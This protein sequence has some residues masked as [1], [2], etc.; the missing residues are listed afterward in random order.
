ME[1]QI[2]H[3]NCPFCGARPGP[4]SLDSFLDRWRGSPESDFDALLETYRAIL[5]EIAASEVRWKTKKFERALDRLRSWFGGPRSACAHQVDVCDGNRRIALSDCPLCLTSKGPRPPDRYFTLW[6]DACSVQVANFFY[7]S[8]IV[9]FAILRQL[10]QWA[11]PQRLGRW[12]DL[13]ALNQRTLGAVGL[14]ECPLC[15]RHTTC[16]YG[17]GS[18]DDPHRCRWCV[19]REGPTCITYISLVMDEDGGIGL[20][21]ST[22]TLPERLGGHIVPRTPKL[23]RGWRR[24]RRGGTA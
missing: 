13:L 10:P 19:D 4:V 14:L 24:K 17:D 12:G 21:H 3:F 16:L 9:M 18:G 22:Q 6:R 8:G 23:R 11:T 5:A 15:G 20:K 1:P 7:E 2:F